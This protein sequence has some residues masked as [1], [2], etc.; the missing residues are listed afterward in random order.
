MDSAP[1]QRPSSIFFQRDGISSLADRF[2][3][4]AADALHEQRRPL[5]MN[6]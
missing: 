1:T 2:D 5:N 4:R 3:A 6:T